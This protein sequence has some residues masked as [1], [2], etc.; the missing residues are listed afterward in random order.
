MNAIIPLAK[1][2]ALEPQVA[3]LEGIVNAG[4]TISNTENL[5]ASY[6]YTDYNNA[7]LSTFRGFATRLSYEGEVFKAVKVIFAVEFDG[8]DVI[9]KIRKNDFTT[10][11]ATKQLECIAG[12]QTKIFI[13]DNE[14]TP[15]DITDGNFYVSIESADISGC[16]VN[17]T[18]I[19]RTARVSSDV[20]NKNKYITT[21]TS[22]WSDNATATSNSLAIEVLSAEQLTIALPVAQDTTN[23]YKQVA[24]PPKIYGV[25]GKEM[26]IYFDA[27]VSDRYTEYNID[28]V[29]TVGTQQKER[30]TY[31]PGSAATTT[32]N[33]NFYDKFNNFVMSATTSIIVVADSAKSGSNPKCLFIGDSLT[34]ANT[35]TGELLTLL[36]AGDVMDITLIGTKGSSTNLHEGIAGYKVADFYVGTPN[37]SPFVFTGVFNFSTYMSTNGFAEVDY[38]FIMLGINDVFSYTSDADVDALYTLNYTKLEAMITNIKAFN[39]NVKIGIMIP[40][41]PSF[42]QDSFGKNYASVQN[43]WRFKR[44]IHRYAKKLIAAYTGR[45]ASNIYAIPTNCCIDTE[46]NMSVETVAVNSRNSTTVVRQ[47][48]GV[49]PATSG[50][51][52]IADCVYYAL[53]NI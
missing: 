25:V 28:V 35:Y 14:I 40:T 3:D 37:P 11:I 12:N 52:Q 24:L 15:A 42:N 2:L 18:A 48:N 9:C 22:T 1:V 46:N 29:C 26:N 20:S 33:I 8:Y 41:P 13:F 45:E 36:G 53:K 34:A 47:S 51:Y 44:N 43:Q 19:N 39:A 38:V 17:T 6:D 7:M 32:M 49:H 4:S 50:Y 10:V 30:W 27:L 21:G 23:W 5:F 16:R 31:V